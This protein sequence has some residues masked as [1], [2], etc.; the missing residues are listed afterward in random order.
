MKL[1][2]RAVAS[3]AFAAC[4]AGCVSTPAVPPSASVASRAKAV[5]IA[6]MNAVAIGRSTKADVRAA[7]GETQVMSFDTG[8]EVWVYRLAEDRRTEY[9]IL[10]TPSGIVSKTRMRPGTT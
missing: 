6:R 10:F 4:M 1:L 8:Y 3:I 5:P 9:V 2:S 7:L